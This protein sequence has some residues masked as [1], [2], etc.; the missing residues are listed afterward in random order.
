ME[1]CEAILCRD[2]LCATSLVHF[3]VLET[4]LRASGRD[5]LFIKLHA[6]ETV[7][8]PFELLWLDEAFDLEAAVTVSLAKNDH[9]FGVAV[10]NT[11]RDPRLALRFAS[12]Q[13]LREFAKT[14]SIFYYS[15]YGRW[16]LSG[17]P[18]STGAVGATALLQSRSWKVQE[19]LYFGDKH[20]VFVALG[21]GN[22]APMYYEFGGKHRQQLHITAL[23]GIAKDQQRELSQAAR[24]APSRTDMETYR[25]TSRT[26]SLVSSYAVKRLSSFKTHSL[27]QVSLRVPSSCQGPVAPLPALALPSPSSRLLRPPAEDQSS[28]ADS[29]KNKQAEQALLQIAE[30][31]GHHVDTDPFVPRG[32]VKFQDTHHFPAVSGAQATTMVDR[33]LHKA[34]SR[35]QE[36]VKATAGYRRSCTWVFLESALTCN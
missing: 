35:A 21:A 30:Q 16:K 17:L 5:A 14:H 8:H 31:Q 25:P 20:C 11:K 28:Q 7:M 10:K 12:M 18:S 22:T 4:L 33:K 24:A 32:Q 3:D 19:M 2:D 36:V 23:N 29:A 9:I 34:L 27:L 6:D 26:S 13:K 15:Q 1:S